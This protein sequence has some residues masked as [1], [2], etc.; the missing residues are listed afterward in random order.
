MVRC[1]CRLRP[2]D[3]CLFVSVSLLVLRIRG[4][5]LLHLLVQAA[6]RDLLV[7]FS[8]NDLWLLIRIGFVAALHQTPQC[9]WLRVDW[10]NAAPGSWLVLCCPPRP[11]KLSPTK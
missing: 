11:W 8:K 7:Q 2:T 1:S 6:E 9:H 4:V 10:P 5:L 3:A